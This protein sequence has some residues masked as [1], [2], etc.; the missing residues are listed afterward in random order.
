MKL[1]ESIILD[2]ERGDEC[3]GLQYYVCGFFMTF[4]LRKNAP[5]INFFR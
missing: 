5:I 3:I 1:Y 4:L 2:S